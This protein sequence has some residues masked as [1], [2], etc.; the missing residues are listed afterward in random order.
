MSKRSGAPQTALRPLHFKN[1]VNRYAEGAVLIEQ[2]NTHVLC[3]A[4]V[5]SRV[6]D[7][8]AG[9]GRGWVTAEYAMLPRATHS[10]SRRE[11]VMG[12]RNARASEIS[13]L[14]GRALRAAVDLE[15]LG[16]TMITVDCDV[17]QADGGTRCASITGGMVALAR[18]LGWLKKQKRL[19]ANPLKSYVAAV[20]VGLVHGDV[21]LD[22]CYEQDSR[23]DVDMNIVMDDQGRYIELQGTAEGRP[24]TDRELGRMKTAAASGIVTILE[25]Q[26]RAAGRG[27]LKPEG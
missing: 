7:W 22:L 8:L 1:K 6:P 20:S 21:C 27:A 23:A 25:K 15:I 10:R 3:T 16:E 24:F 14:I 11:S 4:T 18:A 13:R 19:N 5:E 2:G 9:K 12:K 26:K 17:L